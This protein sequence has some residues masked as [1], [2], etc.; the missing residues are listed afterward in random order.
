MKRWPGARA[1]S[2]PTKRLYTAF[3]LG[4]GSA[5]QLFGLPVWAQAMKAAR[6][7]VGLSKPVGDPFVLAGSFVVHGNQILASDRADHAGSIP[8]LTELSQIANDARAMAA[9]A[10]P[11]TAADPGQAGGFG[12]A[13][14]LTSPKGP[15]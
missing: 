13:E 5:G 3:G 2:D 8:D 4:R 14:G 6:H 9:M 12:A 15:A 1:V 7:G 11:I 10:E